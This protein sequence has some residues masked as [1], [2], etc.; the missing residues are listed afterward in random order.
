MRNTRSVLSNNSDSKECSLPAIASKKERRQ[1]EPTS[2]SQRE[3][4]FGDRQE[5]KDWK[6]EKV[7]ELLEIEA[8]EIA[9]R[10]GGGAGNSRARVS[11]GNVRSKVS[12]LSK[13]YDNLQD[14]FNKYLIRRTSNRANILKLPKGVYQ[15]SEPFNDFFFAKHEELYDYHGNYG[16]RG[17]WD[18]LYETEERTSF[19]RSEMEEYNESPP[20]IEPMQMART[21]EKAECL[22]IISAESKEY[23]E[24]PRTEDSRISPKQGKQKMKLIGVAPKMTKDVDTQDAKELKI[25][26]REKHKGTQW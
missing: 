8:K 15:Q 5:R 21:N 1:R 17:K 19:T 12:I 4:W 11:R 24:S 6:L 9:E 14:S 7:K 25:K 20:P 16:L 2:E 18:E 26:M 13:R 3:G 23:M 10:R 22:R